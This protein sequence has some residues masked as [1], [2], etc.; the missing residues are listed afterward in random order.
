MTFLSSKKRIAVLRGG[1]SSEY[2]V[3]LKSGAHVL[4]LLRQMED[5]Y[6]PVD[7][8]ISRK[9]EWHHEGLVGEPHDILNHVDLVWN[10]LHGTYGEDG[11]VQMLLDNMGIPYTG[12][13]VTPSV[14]AMNKEMAKRSYALHSLATPRHEFLTTETFNDSHLVF[15]FQNYLHPVIIKPSSGGSSLGIRLANTFEELKS[16]VK[17][18]LNNSGKVLV[19]EFIRGKEATCGV[20]ENARGEKIYALLPVE[21]R[22]KGSHIFGY[23]EKYSGETEE[24]CPG[25]FRDTESRAI[26]EM[27]KRAHEILGL[28]HYSRSDFIVTKSGKVYILET[29]SLPGFTQESLFPKSLHAVGWHPRDFTDHVVN[30][31]LGKI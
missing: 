3:S 7:V 17:E 22:K 21:I 20:V 5:K 10:A 27:A 12:S 2:D 18:E 4:S 15:I 26:A 14:F 6:N 9:G 8:F 28:R 13:G 25:N 30:L 31:A 11:Q 24:I 19:E 1:P 16:F 29:N 23:N